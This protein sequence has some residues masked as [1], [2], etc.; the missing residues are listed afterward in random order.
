[1]EA[2][3]GNKLHPGPGPGS[4]SELKVVG[5]GAVVD[6]SSKLVGAVA[7]GR[8]ASVHGKDFWRERLLDANPCYWGLRRCLRSSRVREQTTHGKNGESSAG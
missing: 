4:C 6:A 3:A 5:A 7:T 1:M 2:G 8:F